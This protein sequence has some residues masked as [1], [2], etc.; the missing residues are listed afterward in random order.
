MVCSS[1]L[2]FSDAFVGTHHFGALV[3]VSSFGCVY[4]T[5]WEI[6]KLMLLLAYS[7]IPYSIFWCV[8]ILSA[9]AHWHL[10]LSLKFCLLSA[11]C[12]IV[13]RICVFAAKLFVFVSY[14]LSTCVGGSIMFET[15]WV[16]SLSCYGNSLCPLFFIF[17]ISLWWLWFL[18]CASVYDG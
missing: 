15:H 12:R 17:L 14:M 4:D 2:S 7:L 5:L 1:I 6:G 8:V 13:P 10:G 9:L 16:F 11:N 18:S 3:L